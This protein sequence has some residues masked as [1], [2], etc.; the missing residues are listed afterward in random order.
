MSCFVFVEYAGLPLRFPQGTGTT[1][2]KAST[3][4]S[5]GEAWYAAYQAGLNPDR[6]RILP[7]SVTLDPTKRSLEPL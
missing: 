6:C 3:F 7:T 2:E 1:V 4:T 5:E